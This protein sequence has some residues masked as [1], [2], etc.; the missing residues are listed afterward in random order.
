M[1]IE[2]AI[3][4]LLTN[5]AGVSALVSSR[6]YPNIKPQNPTLPAI[7][8]R[9]VSHQDYHAFSVDA[10]VRTARFQLDIWASTYTA[11]NGL[12][13]ATHA[14]ME[15]WT[16]TASGSNGNTNVYDARRVTMLDLYDDTIEQHHVAIDYIIDYSE[17]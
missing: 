14:A 7:S 13:A 11:A 1:T 8:Y 5:D 3:F 16:Q 2:A 15:R 10:E 9:R 6:V 17:A 4:A 12:A